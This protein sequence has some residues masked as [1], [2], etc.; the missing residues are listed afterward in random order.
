MERISKDNSQKSIDFIPD[1]VF[2]IRNHET[3]K[4]LLFFLEVDL[5]TETIASRERGPKDI[6]KKILNYQILFRHHHYRHYERVFE[7]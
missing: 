1:G 7:S 4:S 3:G 5:G 6:R 2:S